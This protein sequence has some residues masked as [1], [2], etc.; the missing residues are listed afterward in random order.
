MSQSAPS[1]RAR[2]SLITCVGVSYLLSWI[3]LA[4][5]MSRG[6]FA[7]LGWVGPIIFMWVPGLCSLLCRLLLGE[8]FRDIGWG[9]RNRKATLAAVWAPLLVGGVVY[10]LLW[11]TGLAP[12]T[13]RFPLLIIGGILAI[14]VPLLMP[15][16]L[17][18]ELAWRGYLLDRLVETGCRRPVLTLGLI[19][20]VWHLPLMLSGQ[21][22]ESSHIGVTT[23]LFVGMI[24]GFNS[25]ICRLRLLSGNV[26]VPVLMHSVHNAVFQ[27]ALQPVTVKNQW[28]T[29]LGG[30]C[31]AL[32]VLV[33]GLL[34]W[35]MWR[36]SKCKS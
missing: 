1:S 15:I 14:M 10:A 11:G 26:W 2:R 3:W 12:Y 21:Y 4:F 22:C 28:H 20:A 31:G 24:L 19:W 34:A 33:Y 16:S 25:V 27:Y 18:E 7:A 17:G 35:L 9:W 6:G 8:G 30:E 32:T 5:L 23:V 36:E 13:G 29:F